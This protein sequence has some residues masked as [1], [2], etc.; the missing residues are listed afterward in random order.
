MRMAW[1][2]LRTLSKVTL[3][4]VRHGSIRHG[5]AVGPCEGICVSRWSSVTDMLTFR[6][7]TIHTLGSRIL[8][9]APHRLVRR[10]VSVTVLL[11]RTVGGLRSPQLAFGRVFLGMLLVSSLLLG[12]AGAFALINIE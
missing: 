5:G 12:Q 11:L 4:G 6:G 9:M 10:V 7:H 2:F 1:V 8:S 3:H